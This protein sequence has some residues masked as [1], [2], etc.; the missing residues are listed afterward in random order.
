MESG[1]Y[2][3]T[4]ARMVSVWILVWGDFDPDVSD[5]DTMAAIADDVTER[6]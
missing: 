3:G 6:M 1:V 5:L 4:A 2:L